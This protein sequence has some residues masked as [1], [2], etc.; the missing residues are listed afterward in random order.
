[1]TTPRSSSG[2]PLRILHALEATLGGTLRYLDNLVSCMAGSQLILGLAYATDRADANL[3]PLLARAQVS[4]WQTFPVDM[5]RRISMRHDAVGFIGMRRIIAKF[6][7]DIVHCHSSKAGALCRLAS[8][9]LAHRPLIVYSPHALAA[10]LGRQYLYIE[11]ALRLLTDSYIAVSD[12]EKAAIV[13][14]RLAEA[15]RVGVV[16]P[17]IDADHFAPMDRRAARAELGLDDAPL[18]IGVGRL[19]AQKDPLA[20]L[21]VLD[22]LRAQMPSIRGIWVGDGALRSE[23]EAAIASRGLGDTVTLAGWRQDIRPYLAA[24]DVLLS[25]SRFESFGYMVAEAL[26]MERPVVASNV[27]GTVDIMSGGLKGGLYPLDDNGRASA[28]LAGLLTNAALAE[29]VGRLGR[30][31]I[32][33]RF[34][35][36]IMLQ[37]LLHCY[38]AVAIGPLYS[39]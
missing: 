25:T 8:A 3:G 38:E 2:R 4:S 26:A 35:P 34:S 39:T 11:R 27:T 20:F 9:T 37:R 29:S 7:P 13:S 10:P 22:R 24:A 17:S 21:D 12:S 1:M 33:H 18:V 19:T 15:D 32:A 30:Q 14:Y 5:R 23:F 6:Q 28:M 36:A 31:A 16:Y